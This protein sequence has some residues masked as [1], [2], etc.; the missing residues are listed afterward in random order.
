M[1]TINLA[2]YSIAQLNQLKLDIDKAIVDKKKEERYAVLQEM[3]AVA[4]RAGMTM[5]E[6]LGN[7][8][9]GKRSSRGAVAP[10][11]KNP[12]NADETWT[13]RGRQPKWVAAYVA[14]GGQLSAIEI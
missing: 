1:T 5:D 11:Y 10:K 6:V 2:S 7:V 12:A 14:K 9:A 3:K 8:K 13:G 4:E